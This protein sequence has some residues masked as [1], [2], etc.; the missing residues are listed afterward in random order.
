MADPLASE[1]EAR[2]EALE[3]EI[4]LRIMVQKAKAAGLENDPLYQKRMKEYRKTLLINLH[5]EQLTK[6]MEPSDEELK[7]YYEANRQ[8]FMVPEARKVQMVVVKTQRKPRV[9]RARSKQA[10]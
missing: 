6:T 2:R 9:S 4:D 1:D 3:H 10:T 7:A 8:R 5:R